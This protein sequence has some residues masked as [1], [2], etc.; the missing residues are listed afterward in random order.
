MIL[1]WPVADEHGA[2]ER[3]GREKAVA[4]LDQ[5]GVEGDHVKERSEAEFLLHQPSQGAARW[6]KKLRIE[7]EFARVVARLAM[8]VDGPRE[9]GGV[10]I[11]EPV[12]ISKP[13]VR[14]GQD[15]QIPRAR[16]V[17]TDLGAFLALVNL[18]DPEYALKQVANPRSVGFLAD[19]NVGQLMVADGEGSAVEGIEGFAERSGT[20][21]EKPRLAKLPID[22]DGARDVA[23]P[24]LAD[25]PN[26]R[27]G[28]FRGVEQGGGG[29]IEFAD[30]PRH[31][32]A[33]YAE[34]LGIVVEVRQVHQREVGTLR[35]ENL[36]R[37][38]ADPL[39]ARKAGSGSPKCTK[40]KRAELGFETGG[41][42]VGGARD[43]ENLVAVGSVPR[44]GGDAVVDRRPL[45]EP[46]EKFC[47][48]KNPPMPLGELARGQI[49][50]LSLEQGVG[51]LP[52]ANFPRLA[53]QPAV[54]HDP[55]DLRR[56]PRQE[57]RLSRASDRGEH[58]GEHRKASPLRQHLE[59][60]GVRKP[61]RGQTDGI[62]QDHGGGLG[63]ESGSVE[64]VGH[65]D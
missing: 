62:D 16:V 51:L 65:C 60:R 14:L 58:F 23:M 21:V 9:V 27:A 6:P 41:K 47:R 22:E 57:T 52:E 15:H 59:T 42:S 35:L 43:A 24:V 1:A 8:D 40:G 5:L 50:R 49:N 18:C 63:H 20:D 7:K 31:V 2:I 44:L 19:V 54:A 4:P 33:R 26:P 48:A 64:G 29:G 53:E 61:S 38:L 28:R 46:P 56:L 37:G 17:Q 36:R 30:E 3:V 55:V 45:I 32:G 11:V 34:P 39:R 12:R 13:C 10:A 25:D